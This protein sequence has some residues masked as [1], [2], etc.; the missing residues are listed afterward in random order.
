MSFPA[1]ADAGFNDLSFTAHSEFHVLP[2]EQDWED[3]NK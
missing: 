2:I 1:T 3:T